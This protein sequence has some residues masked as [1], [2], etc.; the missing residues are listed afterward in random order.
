MSPRVFRYRGGQWDLGGRTYILGI[1]NVTPDSFSDGSA[2]NSDPSYQVERAGRLLEEGADGLDLGAESTR[3]GHQPLSADEEWHRLEP[4]LLAIRNAYPEAPLSVDTYKAVVAERALAAGADIINDIW[5]LSNDADMARVAASFRAGLIVMF[6]GSGDPSVP[7]GL[8][9]IRGFFERALTTADQAGI[10][11][12][13][14]LVDPGIGFRLQGEGVWE[15]L[16]HL[17]HFRGLGAG[18]LIGHS[19][20]RF[21]GAA[22]GTAD[23]SERDL[24]TAVLSALV[25]LGGADVVRVHNPWTTR[26]AL[27]MAEQWRAAGGQN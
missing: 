21:I 2:K 25:A 7:V 22:T 1:L 3:P 20:K 18:I 27:L 13:A 8:D 5:G 24:A 16:T 19:R 23:P 15:V 6:N 17:E 9:A 12:E 10:P 11:S 14:L 4:V 26:Q